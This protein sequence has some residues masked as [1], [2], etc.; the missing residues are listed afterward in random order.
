MVFE[1]HSV[2]D[3]V[4]GTSGGNLGQG[5]YE[6]DALLF[7]GFQLNSG[8]ELLPGGDNGRPFP[9][10][11]AARTIVHALGAFY[12]FYGFVAHGAIKSRKT[13][14]VERLLFAT[15]GAVLTDI[16]SVFIFDDHH[17][18]VMTRRGILAVINMFWGHFDIVLS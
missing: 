16:R 9:F 12:A 15:F 2:T 8:I 3:A 10:D 14:N 11:F 4:I 17:P 18:G 7:V 13:F 1:F 6:M 5:I